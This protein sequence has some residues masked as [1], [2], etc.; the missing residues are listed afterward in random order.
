MSNV[1][2]VRKI[3]R[4]KIGAVPL[5]VRVPPDLLADLD[6]F[7]SEECPGTSRPDALRKLA[8]EALIGMGIRKPG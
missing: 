5:S 2:N 1:S 6:R 8:S 4:P 7:I 3:G